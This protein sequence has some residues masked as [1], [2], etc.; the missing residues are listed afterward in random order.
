MSWKLECEWKKQPCEGA[1]GFYLTTPV[2]VR[3]RR[4]RRKPGKRHESSG[5]SRISG[6]ISGCDSNGAAYSWICGRI[7]GSIG[8]KA[9]TRD[10]LFFVS[11][12]YNIQ[13]N[14]SFSYELTKRT[15][16]FALTKRA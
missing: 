8:H 14:T 7:C 12:G 2:V 9:C 15:W 1:R 6:G 3:S 4:R 10:F 5:S 11:F 16:R 13:V